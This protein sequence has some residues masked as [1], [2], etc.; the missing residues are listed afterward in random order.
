[1]VGGV[2]GVVTV[3][4]VR[5][6][7]GGGDHFTTRRPAMPGHA[8]STLA[9]RGEGALRGSGYRG[10]AQYQWLVC[11]KAQALAGLP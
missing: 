9:E 2:G 11:Q 8:E 4:P 6:A 7:D 3:P 10:S 5:R 1:M